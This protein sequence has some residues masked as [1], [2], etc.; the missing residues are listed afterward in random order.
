MENL[1]SQTFNYLTVIDGPIK[2]GRR[3]YWKC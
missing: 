1:L 3:Y 2:R